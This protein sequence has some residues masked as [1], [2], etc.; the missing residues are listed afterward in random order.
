MTTKKLTTLSILT[1]LS[2]ILSIT[3]YFP[4]FPQAP[5]L[6]YDPGDIPLLLIALYYGISEGILTTIIVAILM[7]IFTGQG[8]PIGAFMHF[9]A[10]GTLIT[11]AGILYRKTKNKILSLLFGTISMAMVMAIANLILTPIYLGVPRSSIIPL[12]IPVIIPFNLIK[13]GINSIIAY[14]ISSINTL[15]IYLLEKKE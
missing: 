1:A 7:A 6:L 8:G 10:T 12:I 9:L 3:I 14:L 2:I 15:S 5:Y 13:A 11:V 4:I